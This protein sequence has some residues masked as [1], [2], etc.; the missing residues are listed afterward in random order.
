MAEQT[1]FFSPNLFCLIEHPLISVPLYLND[2]N[3][4]IYIYIILEDGVDAPIQS[5]PFP[6]VATVFLALLVLQ[7]PKKVA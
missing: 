5:H 2:I 3:D 1:L 4:I 7:S 6:S